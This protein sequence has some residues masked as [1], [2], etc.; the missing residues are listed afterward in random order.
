MAQQPLGRKRVFVASHSTVLNGPV[1]ALQHFLVRNG[2]EVLRL[3]HP[4]DSYSGRTTRLLRNSQVIRSW[5]RRWNGIIALAWDFS[6]TVVTAIA[7]RAPLAVGAN[8][9]DSFAVLV[10]RS[11][12]RFRSRV[13]Y[14]AADYSEDRFGGGILDLAYRTIERLVLRHAD[15][16]VSNTRRAEAKRLSM[17]LSAEHSLVIPN[18]V[19]LESPLFMPKTIRRDRFVYVGSVTEE[20]GLYDLLLVLR[21]I[22]GSITIIGQGSDWDRVAALCLQAGLE[23]RLQHNRPHEFVLDFLHDFDGFGLAPY[24]LTSRWT[25]F[26]SPVKVV[27]Y[28]AS[29]VPVV[30]SSVPEIAEV[31]ARDRLGIVYDEVAL[32]PIRSA[33]TEFDVGA[34]NVRARAFYDRYNTDSLLS[35]IPL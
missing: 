30:T 35:Q 3:D 21:P 32:E 29:G 11:V 19:R 27:E 24:N 7:I 8:N 6:K 23:H 16:V 25:Y 10:A 33:L 31:V 13:I 18:G 5:R 20:H 14:F 34:F 22:I 1:D 2:W 28:I 26:C 12:G 15:L 4:L 9:F 17:G